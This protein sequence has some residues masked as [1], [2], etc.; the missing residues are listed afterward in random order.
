MSTHLPRC[1]YLYD[2]CSLILAYCCVQLCRR[3]H[4][5]TCICIV[6]DSCVYLTISLCLQFV[7]STLCLTA[8][9]ALL[10]VCVRRGASFTQVLLLRLCLGL[11]LLLIWTV[12][13]IATCAS[14][15]ALIF[16]FSFTSTLTCIS[17]CTSFSNTGSSLATYAYAPNFT[18]LRLRLRL[19]LNL[20]LLV[21]VLLRSNS[22]ST[23][24]VSVT[25]MLRYV[26][27]GTYLDV[28]VRVWF[29]FTCTSLFNLFTYVYMYVDFWVYLCCY[30]LRLLLRAPLLLTLLVLILLHILLLRL[31]LSLHKCLLVLRYIS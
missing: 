21:F 28:L 19:L 29:T 7:C 27:Q 9:H 2:D 31:R 1:S 12:T 26:H 5:H 3:A 23:H 20:L 6:T 25:S 14:I 13:A 4:V 17:T 8:T 16:N 11:G 22:T 30:G 24:T 18:C 15:D 10:L